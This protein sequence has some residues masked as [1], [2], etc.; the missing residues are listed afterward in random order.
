M[1]SNR[2]PDARN[3]MR[4]VDALAS[5]ALKNT[6]DAPKPTNELL[7]TSVPPNDNLLVAHVHGIFLGRIPLRS[8]HIQKWPNTLEHLQCLHCGGN[9]DVGPPVPVCRHYESQV[10]QYWVFGPFCRPSCSLG[11]ICENDSTSKQMSATTELLRR[12]FGITEIQIAPPRASHRRFGGPL[13][14]SDFYGSSGYIC[15]TTLQPPFVTFANYVVGVHQASQGPHGNPQGPQSH[16]SAQALLPQSAGRLIGLTRPSERSNAI[17]ERK[18]TGKVPMIL[19]FLATLSS[20]K[21]VKDHTESIDVKAVK[22]RSRSATE[23]A[24]TEVT[25]FLKQYVKKT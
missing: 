24:P 18:P 17:A 5:T 10:D 23:A 7:M 13:S 22:K 3:P 16:Q 12:F 15:T 11:Y 21:D 1:L 2:A 20:F 6:A 19:E 25:N 4:M 9:C 8:T 14:D